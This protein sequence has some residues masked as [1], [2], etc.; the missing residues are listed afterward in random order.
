VA[1]DQLA[2]IKRLPIRLL[3]HAVFRRRTWD[4]TARL[5]WASTL[6]CRVDRTNTARE[7]DAFVTVDSDL[8]RRGVEGIVATASFAALGQGAAG[9]PP[10]RCGDACWWSRLRDTTSP[11]FQVSHL[12]VDSEPGHDPAPTGL[13]GHGRGGLA[14]FS[15]PR[16]DESVLPRRTSQRAFERTQVVCRRAAANQIT[17]SLAS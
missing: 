12:G 9:P 17:M 4:L 13:E 6:Q 5:G 2:R 15:E 10:H 7:A 16:P 8:G 3:G 1:R 11:L 14:G